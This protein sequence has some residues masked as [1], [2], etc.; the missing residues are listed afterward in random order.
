MKVTLH[1]NTI[2]DTKVVISKIIFDTFDKSF[3]LAD[4][5]ALTLQ[6]GHRTSIDLDYFSEID[7]D[8]ESLKIQILK[9]F[10]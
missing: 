1:H 2:T 4:G 8:T 3:Y 9:I 7:F 10:K 5:T 6:I